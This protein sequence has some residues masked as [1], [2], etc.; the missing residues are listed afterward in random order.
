MSEI[1]HPP[2]DQDISSLAELELNYRVPRSFWTFGET[3]CPGGDAYKSIVACLRHF[4]ECDGGC[5]ECE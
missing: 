5:K 3:P 4:V 2:R 1:Y